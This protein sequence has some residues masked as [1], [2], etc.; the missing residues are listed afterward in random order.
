M[1]HS[2]IVIPEIEYHF[3]NFLKGRN[4][5]NEFILT[6]VIPKS[7]EVYSG[8]VIEL[9]FNS[10]FDSTSYSHMC[11]EISVFLDWPRTLQQ[12]ALVHSQA[13]CFVF[14][15]AG[16]FNFLNLENDDFMLINILLAYRTS[17]TGTIGWINYDN[18]ST[19]LSKMLY[20]YLDLVLNNNTSRFNNI[21]LMSDSSSLLETMFEIYLCDKIFEY[22][23]T[24]SVT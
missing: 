24:Q 17:G 16:T 20:I 3:G 6:P 10:T 1:S 23:E 14:D 19:N 13:T 15:D 9:M 12:R 21:T 8:S 18:L 2:Y 5:T 22:I 11:R 4:I 7:T